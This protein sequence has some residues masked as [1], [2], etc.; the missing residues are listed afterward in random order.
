MLEA[1][2]R[3]SYTGRSVSVGSMELNDLLRLGLTEYQGDSIETVPAY[4]KL[5]EGRLPARA[6]GAPSH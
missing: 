3:L 6:S 2:E 1:D 4:T 5:A